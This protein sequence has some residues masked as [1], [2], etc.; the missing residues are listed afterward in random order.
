[1]LHIGVCCKSLASGK[2]LQGPEAI[3]ITKYENR[4]VERVSQTVHL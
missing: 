4:L 2:L 1:L 3:Y